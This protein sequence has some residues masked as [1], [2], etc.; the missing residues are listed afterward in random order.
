VKDLDNVVYCVVGSSSTACRVQN[1]VY[2]AR[3]TLTELRRLSKDEKLADKFRGEVGVPIDIGVARN[4][5][6]MF[7]VV[8]FTFDHQTG[9][10]PETNYR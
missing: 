8:G 4:R 2:A 1:L 6:R 3:A 5:I 9:F 10:R 7:R